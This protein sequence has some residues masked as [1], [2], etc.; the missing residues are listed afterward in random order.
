MRPVRGVLLCF[1]FALGCAAGSTRIVVSRAGAQDAGTTRPLLER[2]EAARRGLRTVVGEFVQRKQMALF[3]TTVETRGRIVVRLPD[4]LRWETM[5]DD[6]AVYLVAGDR[7]AYR[8]SAGR[9]EVS[10]RQAGAMG[11]VVRDLAV[12]L[13][14]SLRS[15]ERRYEMRE[16]GSVLVVVPRDPAVR[17]SLERMRVTFS[18]PRLLPSRFELDERG[19]DRTSIELR[20]VRVN[21][22]VPERDLRLE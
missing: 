9:G 20:N 5:G 14:G 8:S 15:L 1:A 19:G 6:A 4:R 22:T 10:A 7:L 12:F 17:R 13:G 2:I 11:A 18:G 3:A 16:E 21:V